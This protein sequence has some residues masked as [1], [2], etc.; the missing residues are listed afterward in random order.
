MERANAAGQQC[1]LET[2]NP[3][4]ITFYEHLGFKRIAE[5]VAEPSGIRFWT[6]RRDPVAPAVS[7]HT[8]RH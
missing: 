7:A 6:F 8:N 3:A 1:Y 4:N 2:A 5:P